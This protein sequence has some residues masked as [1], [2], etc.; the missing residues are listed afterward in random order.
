[1]DIFQLRVAE[2][3]KKERRKSVGKVR[4]VYKYIIRAG[5]GD[6]II[7]ALETPSSTAQASAS[8]LEPEVLSV[9]V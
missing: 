5:R 8:E 7:L 3:R 9:A 4:N 6:I 2:Y 1:M